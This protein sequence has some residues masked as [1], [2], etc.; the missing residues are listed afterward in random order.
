[1]DQKTKALEVI[2]EFIFHNIWNHDS[3]HHGWEVTFDGTKFLAANFATGK[4]YGFEINYKPLT[5]F[6]WTAIIA[7]QEW[8]G[9][10]VVED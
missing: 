9:I 1:M 4:A 7:D 2:D 3:H 10:E 5:G 8:E 6:D